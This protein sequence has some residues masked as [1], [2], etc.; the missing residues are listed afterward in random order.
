MSARGS[1][2][3]VHIFDGALIE[4]RRLLERG[5]LLLK[6]SKIRIQIF[7]IRFKIKYY[8][9]MFE[10]YRIFNKMNTFKLLRTKLFKD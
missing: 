2:Q 9:S 8:L 7:H 4:E 1:L 3:L 5:A 10:K 6:F